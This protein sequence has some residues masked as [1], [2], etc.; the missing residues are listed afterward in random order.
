MDLYKTEVRLTQLLNYEGVFYGLDKDG[1]IWKMKTE[2]V[3]GIEKTG[4]YPC[5]MDILLTDAQKR[6]NKGTTK[7]D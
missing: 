2:I 3:N 4:W 1:N 5:K 6:A 7:N